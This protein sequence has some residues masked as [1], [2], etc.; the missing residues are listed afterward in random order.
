MLNGHEQLLSQEILGGCHGF[1]N[2]TWLRGNNFPSKPCQDQLKHV[3]YVC[4]VTQTSTSPYT[5]QPLLNSNFL[6]PFLE[7][8]YLSDFPLAIKHFQQKGNVDT[9]LTRGAAKGRVTLYKGPALK[10]LTLYIP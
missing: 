4:V 6:Y 5:S 8:D 7:N 2:S 3:I 9:Q 10:V 1:S